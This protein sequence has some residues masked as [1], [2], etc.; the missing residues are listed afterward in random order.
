MYAG[1]FLKEF[2]RHPQYSDLK[3]YKK[4]TN[5]DFMVAL[6]KLYRSQCPFWSKQLVVI[7]FCILVKKWI[8]NMVI[9]FS[10]LLLARRLYIDGVQN[11]KNTTNCHFIFLT[12]NYLTICM[13]FCIKMN[14]I[15]NGYWKSTGINMCQENFLITIMVMN[16]MNNNKKFK[17]KLKVKKQW[18]IKTNKRV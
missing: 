15:G 5:I 6:R 8:I 17:T 9:G 18:I 3:Y 4:K 14:I 13:I 2:D 10:I 7:K 1:D 11:W 12:W 16:T